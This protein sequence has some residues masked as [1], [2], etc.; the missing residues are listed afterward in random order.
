MEKN[1]AS[2]NIT[3]DEIAQLQELYIIKLKRDIC[4]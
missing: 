1:I 4:M 3:L 2:G